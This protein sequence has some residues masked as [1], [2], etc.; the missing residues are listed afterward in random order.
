MLIHLDFL[1]TLISLGSSEHSGWF[2]STDSSDDYIPSGSYEL[3]R[4]S[5]SALSSGTGSWFSASSA[6]SSSCSAW[7]S[8]SWAVSNFA[9]ILLILFLSSSLIPPLNL[10]VVYRRWGLILP[11]SVSFVS[12]KARYSMNGPINLVALLS[13]YPL[14]DSSL[15]NWYEWSLIMAFF[16]LSGGLYKNFATPG[17]LSI[18][19]NILLNLLMINNIERLYQ[20]LKILTN[21]YSNIWCVK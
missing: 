15:R 13:S 6:C 11:K 19:Y 18:W 3:S 4:S 9:L 1:S 20:M 17:F 7:T 12:F 14:S 5:S 21:H 8:G 16:F 2:C 10:N